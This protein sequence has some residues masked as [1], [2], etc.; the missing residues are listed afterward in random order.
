M[1]WVRHMKG[2]PP[3]QILQM[4][5]EFH[6]MGVIEARPGV[7][8]DADFPTVLFVETLP[9]EVAQAYEAAVPKTRNP[10]QKPKPF[11]V[12]GWESQEQLEAFRKARGVKKR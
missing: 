9:L 7:R 8:D 5:R 11:E 10:E 2:S 4:V 3:D 6:K 1:N 12:A